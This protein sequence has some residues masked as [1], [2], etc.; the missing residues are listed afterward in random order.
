MNFLYK[1]YW[2][3]DREIIKKCF[4]QE[5]DS[6]ISSS[7]ASAEEGGQKENEYGN[8]SE[9]ERKTDP[10]AVQDVVPVLSD[11]ADAIPEEQLCYFE[12]PGSGE[13]DD[14]S[15]TSAATFNIMDRNRVS[16]RHNRSLSA[17][18]Y[19]SGYTVV[20]S[21]SGR[22]ADFPLRIL[23]HSDMVGAIIG[24]Q[25]LTI[26]T[27]T[28]QTR[29]RVDVHR[30]D[31]IGSVEKAITI[32]GNP[33]NCT[34]ACKKILEVMQEE[35]NN[36]NKGEIVLKMLAHNNLVGR[37]IGKAGSTIKKI[38]QET[39]TKITVSSINEIN[40]FNVERIITVKGS[41]DSMSKAE[42]MISSRLKQSYENDMQVCSQTM[43]FPGLHS[44]G[45]LSMGA[46]NNQ[47]LTYPTGRPTSYQPSIYPTGPAPPAY[48]PMYTPA[49]ALVTSFSPSDSQETS[50]LYVPHNTVGAVIGTKGSTIRNMIRYSGASIKIASL[51][52]DKSP[53]VQPIDRKVTIVGTP[54]SQWK[55][56]YLIFEKMREEGLF[57]GAD[58]VR[59]TIEIV[60]P[61]SQV[62]RIIG[63]GGQNVRELQRS[64]GAMIKLP[65]ALN[66]EET[67]VHI[68]GTFYSVQSAQRRIRSMITP[69]M[70]GMEKQAGPSRADTSQ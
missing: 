23:V 16:R 36:T 45:M 11:A 61:S 42:S 31:S 46:M 59:L 47:G 18:G 50:Y 6:Q 4:N 39:D 57:V 70:T 29:A 26:R 1:I 68:I 33:E 32:Y 41:I 38:M 67:N 60:V 53:A 9:T 64:T 8:Q 55:A 20:G 56:Q 44:M 65:N 49:P 69:A 17:G 19:S 14:L 40:S 10:E 34:N 52:E 48:T 3:I 30:K 12:S 22:H 37:I 63:K 13:S 27:I 24:R 62:G 43:S 28:Q 54:E 21:T 5:G 25:G 2:Y 35:A 51:E 7:N 66:E 58:E 15:V